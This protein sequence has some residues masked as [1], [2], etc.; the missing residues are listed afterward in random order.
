MTEP[1][2]VKLRLVDYGLTLRTSH[3]IIGAAALQPLFSVSRAYHLGCPTL[4][5]LSPSLVDHRGQ[6]Q[7]VAQ[8]DR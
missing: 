4:P 8:S 2:G 5:I 7:P 1:A 6:P 3:G